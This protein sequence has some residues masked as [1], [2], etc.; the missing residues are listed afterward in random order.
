MTRSLGGGRGFWLKYE[1]KTYY[2]QSLSVLEGVGVDAG[3]GGGDWDQKTL[4]LLSSYYT[5]NML[6]D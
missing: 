6:S 2:S 4:I 3:G 5:T 1:L